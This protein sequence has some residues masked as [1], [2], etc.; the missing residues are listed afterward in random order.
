MLHGWAVRRQSDG[1]HYNVRLRFSASGKSTLGVTRRNGGSSTWLG[2]VTLPTALRAGQTIRGG[3]QVTGTSP[4]VIKARVW[5]DGAT[6]PGWQLNHTDS[7]SSRIQASGSVELRD[8]AQAANSQLTITRDDAVRRRGQRGG[9]S[10]PR[11][12][13]P[14]P[15]PTA[16]GGRGSAAIG[17]ASYSIPSG[18]VFVDGARG[19]NSNSGTQSS[20]LKTIQAGVDKAA[21]G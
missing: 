9:R 12:R 7:S 2:G 6:K 19:S 15:L 10:R 4:V 16:T 17:S 3:V 1:S 14:A 21:R 8:F 20:P 13:H 5:V 11:L 18:A